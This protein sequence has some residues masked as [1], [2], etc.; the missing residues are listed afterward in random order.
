MLGPRLL[1]L[2]EPSEPVADALQPVDDHVEHRDGHAEQVD[3][4]GVL[5][6]RLADE[7][8]LLLHRQAVVGPAEVP[9]RPRLG[10]VAD[11][12]DLSLIHI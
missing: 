1:A 7:P 5:S 12:V 2:R 6:Q 10:L 3:L 11:G 9:N 4:F 8:T